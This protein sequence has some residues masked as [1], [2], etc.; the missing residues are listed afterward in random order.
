MHLFLSNTIIAIPYLRY[1]IAV[2][3]CFTF[4]VIIK[5]HYSFK[6]L[7][8]P[9]IWRERERSMNYSLQKFKSPATLTLTLLTW[10]IWW[11]P[12]SARKWR[13]GF[14]SAFKGLIRFVLYQVAKCEECEFDVINVDNGFECED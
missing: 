7:M 11:A 14:N 5:R 8:L 2:L 1:S 9:C 12:T 13:M 6:G 3:I 4:K 10:T